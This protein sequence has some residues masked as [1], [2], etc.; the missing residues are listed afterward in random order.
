MPRRCCWK[1]WMAM[2]ASSVSA[3]SVQGQLMSRAIGDNGRTIGQQM[4]GR[5]HRSLAPS[6]FFLENMAK[7]AGVGADLKNLAAP[8]LGVGGLDDA[9]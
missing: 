3:R 5:F 1:L 9:G 4:V 7:S 6:A 8:P 2:A